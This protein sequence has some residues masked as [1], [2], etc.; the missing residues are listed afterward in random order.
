MRK[1]RRLSLLVYLQ[2]VDEYGLWARE[3]LMWKG[4]HPK[5]ILRVAEKAAA[6]ELVDFR[7]APDRATL[8]YA[9]FDFLKSAI[10]KDRSRDGRV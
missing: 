6:N 7:V 2:A 4:Y 1:Q 8:G 3:H 10:R 9:G 5:T